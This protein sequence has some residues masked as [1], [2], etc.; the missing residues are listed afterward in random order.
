MLRG[1]DRFFSDDLER[2][3]GFTEKILFGAPIEVTGLEEVLNEP[4]LQR[5]VRDHD[6]AAVGAEDLETLFESHTESLH[7]AVDLDAE[8]LEQLRKVTVLVGTGNE[9]P[10]DLDEFK[11]GLDGRRT[12]SLGYEAG[13]TVGRGKL[14]EVTKNLDQTR[15]VEGVDDIGGRE[16]CARVHTH[17]ERPVGTKRKAALGAVEVVGRNPKV[18]KDTV[19]LSDAL[20]A[21]EAAHKAEVTLDEAKPRVG[22]SVAGGVGILV[23]AEKAAFGRELLEDRERVATTPE[24]EVDV[25]AIALEVKQPERVGKK[26]GSVVKVHRGKERKIWCKNTQNF[27]IFGKSF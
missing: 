6:E 20:F 2:S 19:N 25:S 18:G 26:N 9:G 3:Q 12:A 23:E 1:G 8:R 27:A 24:S 16:K 11:G 5:V 15:R 14:A 7:F 4:V 17:I 10:D 21:E 22:R 13:D